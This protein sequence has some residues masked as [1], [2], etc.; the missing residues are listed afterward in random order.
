[1]PD[2]STDLTILLPLK[3]RNLHTLRFLW[4]ADRTR[5]PWPILI[6]DGLVHETIARLLED[7]AIFPNLRLTYLRFPNDTT[8]SLYYRKMADAAARVTSKYVVLA[9]NDDF[10]IPSGV[11]RCIAGLDANPDHVC[12][13]AGVAGFGIHAPAGAAFPNLVGPINRLAYRYSPYDRSRDFGQDTAAERISAWATEQWFSHFYSV[14]RAPVMAQSWR[15]VAEI[16]FTDLPLIELL[17]NTL[18][19]T[20]GKTRSEPSVVSYLRQYGTSMNSAA[21]IGDWVR[22]LLRGRFT[23][24]FEEVLARISATL[25]QTDGVDPAPVAERLRDAWGDWLRASLRH[26]YGTPPLAIRLRQYVRDH[27]PDWLMRIRERRLVGAARQR[28]NFVADLRRDGAS[29][30][31]LRTFQS[32]LADIERTLSGAAFLEFA[33]RVAPDLV[34]GPAPSRS[35]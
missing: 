16:D 24:E 27:S 34:A 17:H 20:C 22:N 15:A 19:L 5:L 14:T 3:G 30:D 26:E 18:V 33:R 7:P 8:L 13:C 2:P 28:R 31:Y 12:W 21:S 1:M 35:K 10:V 23:V 32:E 11:A 29:E 9:D 25:A 4:H 6:A